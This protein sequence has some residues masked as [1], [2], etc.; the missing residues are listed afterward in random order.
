MGRR[1]GR[2]RLIFNADDFGRSASINAAVRRAHQEG[3]LTSAS[4]MVTGEATAEAVEVAREN[5]AL[6]VGLHLTLV[7]GRSVLGPSEIP[8]LVDADGRFLDDAPRAGLRYWAR[9]GLRGQLRREIA[10]QVARFRETGLVLDHLNGH[11]HLHLHPV[12]N[13]LLCENASIWGIERARLTRESLAL[14]LGTMSGRWRYRLGHAL[15]FSLLARAAGRRWDRLGIRHAQGVIGLLA[16]G[17][18]DEG[19]LLRVLP[20]LPPG[21]FE[22][23]SHPSM[24]RFRHEM[25]ALASPRVR[26]RVEALG[27]ERI[28]YQD[29]GRD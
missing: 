25:E 28:R 9:P 6:G 21:D 23:F 24:D 12:V 16:D 17:R 27:F 7:C 4:L 8:D 20:R 18:V 2:R 11:L 14:S 15:V 22:V 29:L 1:E 3:L 26:A 19:Y 5:P 10:A 13:A